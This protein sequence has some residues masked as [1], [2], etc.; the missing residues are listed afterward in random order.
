M[1]SSFLSV[2]ASGADGI[3]KSFFRFLIFKNCEII[4][5]V[6]TSMF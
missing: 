4:N 6:Q 1:L 2:K 5:I 3:V